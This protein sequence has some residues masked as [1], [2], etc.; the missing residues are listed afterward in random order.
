MILPPRTWMATEILHEILL[1]E[2]ANSRTWGGAD[3]FLS[4]GMES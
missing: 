4:V 3:W 2:V 1:P